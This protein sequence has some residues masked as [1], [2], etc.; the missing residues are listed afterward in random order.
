MPKTDF[1]SVDEY[2]AAQP[3][4]VQGILERVR[5]AIRTAVP[6][7]QEVISYKIPSYKLRS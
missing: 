5:S 2:I 6:E 4:A 7:A 3:E 1:A